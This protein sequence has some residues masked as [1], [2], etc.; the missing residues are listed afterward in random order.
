MSKPAMWERAALGQECR[1]QDY[2]TVNR[3]NTQFN[4]AI[5]FWDIR[6]I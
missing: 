3:G 4:I 6:F 5:A 2:P 1:G